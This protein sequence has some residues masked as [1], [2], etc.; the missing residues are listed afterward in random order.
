MWAVLFVVLGGS[1]YFTF[2]RAQPPSRI[3]DV[4]IVRGQNTAQIADL[5]AKKGV[6]SNAYTFRVYAGVTQTEAKLQP[7]RYRL[8]TGLTYYRILKEL[9]KARAVELIGVIIPEGFTA[10]QIAERLAAKTKR[11]PADFYEFIRGQGVGQV[12]PDELP[13][14]LTTV[15]GYLFPKTYQFER[16]A[17]PRAIISRMI[18]QFKLETA[19]IDWTFAKGKNLTKHQIVTVASLIEREARLPE[20]RPLVAAVI[21]N[22]LAK[23]MPLQLCST[24]Q[25]LLPEQKAVLTDKDLKIASPYNTYQQTGLPPGPIS[26]PGIDSIKAALAPA[27]VDYIYFVLMSP[28]GHHAFTNNYNEFLAAKRRAGL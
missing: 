22:R 28:D 4:T 10:K 14:E 16:R 21:Y 24:V 23:G 9:T 25:Y 5:L 11:P 18:D 15:E 7:G 26:S 1:A 12:R 6:I 27:P 8:K 19:S 13:P 3:I 2:G 17:H 20:E